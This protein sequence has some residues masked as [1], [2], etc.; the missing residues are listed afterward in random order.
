MKTRIKTNEQRI[1]RTRRT[2]A[3]I[4]KS[5]R[6][7]LS[8][9]RSLIHIYA[10]IIDDQKGVTLVSASSKEI[11]KDTKKTKTELAKAVGELLAKRA[12]ESKITTIAFDRSSYKY[13]GRVKALAEAAREGG[14]KF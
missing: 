3:K 11:K 4:T 9:F 7:R 12:I 1:R 2:R 6:P 14:L 5:N 8:V 10:Q 13:H